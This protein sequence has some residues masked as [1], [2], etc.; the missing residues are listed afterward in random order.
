MGKKIIDNYKDILKLQ[1]ENHKIHFAAYCNEADILKEDADNVFFNLDCWMAPYAH[2]ETY[3]KEDSKILS[4]SKKI[5]EKNQLRFGPSPQKAK[6][7]K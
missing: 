1:D 6:E 7:V 2:F 4:I 3:M 5:Y